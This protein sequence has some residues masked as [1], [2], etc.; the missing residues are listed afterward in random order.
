MFFIFGRWSWRCRTPKPEA[1]PR[2]DGKD[3]GKDGGDGGDG[4]DDGGCAADGGTDVDGGFSDDGRATG[5]GGE[6]DGGGGE[7]GEQERRKRNRTGGGRGRSN[8]GVAALLVALAK[9]DPSGETIK[10]MMRWV[11]EGLMPEQVCTLIIVE[12]MPCYGHVRA[13]RDFRCR[14]ASCLFHRR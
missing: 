1:A 6:V 13:P 5:W 8:T 7:S 2:A 11:C 9:A 10:S 12:S 14:Q 4:G 3:G